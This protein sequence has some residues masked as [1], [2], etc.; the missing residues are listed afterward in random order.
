[1]TNRSNKPRAAKSTTAKSA[2]TPAPQQP[3]AT[4]PRMVA[5]YDVDAIVCFTLTGDANA[6]LPP[7]LQE[8]L[9]AGLNALGMVI[10]MQTP[11]ATVNCYCGLYAIKTPAQL[12][13]PSKQPE[14]SKP[15]A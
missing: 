6:L 9:L 15:T 13:E 7:A 5:R 4:Q 10:T 3:K 2:A 11:D 8:E 14:P 1:M 12:S